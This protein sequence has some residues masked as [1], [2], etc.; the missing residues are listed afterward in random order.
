MSSKGQVVL[1]KA[2]RTKLRLQSGVPFEVRI[3]DGNVLLVP[4]KPAKRKARIVKDPIT[5]MPVLTLGPGAPII[6][7]N[8]IRK[9]L[10]DFP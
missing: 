3:Q 5:G 4:D 9:L 8:E 6:T 7:H 2:V 1:P 10:E